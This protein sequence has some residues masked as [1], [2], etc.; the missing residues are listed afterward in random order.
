MPDPLTVD[1]V[2]RHLRE[3]LSALEFLP[4]PVTAPAGLRAGVERAKT[5]LYELLWLC[6]LVRSADAGLVV[7]VDQ[8]D[9]EGA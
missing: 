6:E 4:F 8:A 5:H 7:V 9:V 1:E 3:A 2:E